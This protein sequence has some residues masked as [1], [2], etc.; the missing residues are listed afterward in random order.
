MAVRKKREA[1]KRTTVKKKLPSKAASATHKSNYFID[2]EKDVKFISTGCTLLDLVFGGGHPLGRVINIVGDRSSGKTLLAIEA[3][4]NFI[5]AFPTQ[6]VKYNEAESAFDKGYAAALGMPVESID[7]AADDPKFPTANSTVEGFFAHL[8]H[9]CDQNMGTG[10][11]GMYILDSLDALSDAAEMERDLGDNSYG[12]GK[13]KKMSEAFRKLIRKMEE[14]QMTLI[15]VS[16][17]RDKINAAMFGK[18]T[19]R[20]GGK[21]LDFY[22]SIVIFLAEVGKEKKTINKVERVVGVNVKAKTEKNKVGLPFRDCQFPITFGYGID[23]LRASLEWLKTVG[24]LGELGI[25]DKELKRRLSEINAY[26]EDDYLEFVA[27]T[28]ALV[29]TTWREIER[30]FMPVRTKYRRAT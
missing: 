23:S 6:R 5:A 10:L 2:D 4:A 21:A 15:V 7:F 3:C 11:P 9:C 27:K 14:A 17:I 29:K 26:E 13:A 28:D 19:T 16:Q 25:A 20:A 24:S 18:K 30:K 22:A 12:M 8:E 1:S